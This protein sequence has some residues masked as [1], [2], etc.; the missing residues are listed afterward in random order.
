M[1]LSALPFLLLPY[2]SL[3]HLLGFDAAETSQTLPATAVFSL[4]Y[5]VL[6]EG[7]LCFSPAGARVFQLLAAALLW[8]VLVTL[9][10]IVAEAAGWLQ[11]D[12]LFR[13]YAAVRQ[14]ISLALGFCTFVMFHDALTRIGLRSACR[15]IVAGALPS[16]AVCAF[17]ISQGR[18]RIQGFSS[19]PSHLG[20]MLVLAFLPACAYAGLRMRGQTVLDAAWWCG[21]DGHI[22]WNSHHESGVCCVQPVC[23]QGPRYCAA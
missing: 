12:D 8:I 6:R 3:T 1:P 13:N 17:Q 20:D 7:R 15:W 22:Q 9:V 21:I 23:G 10:N 18:F 2:D 5:I 11:G 19:E 4:V 16:L 14:A